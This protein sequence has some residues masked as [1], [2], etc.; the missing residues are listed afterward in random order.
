[1]AK[2]K[3][4]N[5]FGT[6]LGWNNITIPLFGRELEGLDS[7]K[8]NDTEDH[9]VVYGAGKMPIGKSKGNYS[10]EASISLYVEETIALQR[11][12]PPGMRIQEIP[13]FDIPVVY[14]YNGAVVKDI[15]RNCSF[16]D[17]GRECKSGDGK[18]MREYKLVPT[19]IDYDVR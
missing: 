10:A 1:M 11:S 13:D 4:I 6:M 16:V 12:L 3:I 15:I 14:E 19:H 5:K 17:N 18:M 7:I 9:Q 2:A 8:Y